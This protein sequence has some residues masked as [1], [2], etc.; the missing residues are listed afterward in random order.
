MI[1]EVKAKALRWAAGE[2]VEHMEDTDELGDEQ[3]EVAPSIVESPTETGM[4]S[5]STAVWS[6]ETTSLG[7][8]FRR[9]YMLSPFA[10]LAAQGCVASLAFMVGHDGCDRQ[11][12]ACHVR[13]VV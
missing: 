3:D 12:R 6:H 11:L 7:E 2:D 5:V 10:C 13:I 4:D 8:E 9:L 1:E